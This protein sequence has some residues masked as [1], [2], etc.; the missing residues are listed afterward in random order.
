MKFVKWLMAVTVT[1]SMGVAVL[2]VS[3]MGLDQQIED[4]RDEM[5]SLSEEASNIGET[6]N[7]LEEEKNQLEAEG[8]K[9]EKE[10]DSILS[11][12]QNLNDDINIKYEEIEE[13]EKQLAAAEETEQEQYEMMKL[14]IKAMYE[15]GE[16]NYLE[17]LLSSSSVAELLN[18]VDYITSLAEYDNDMLEKYRE[19]ADAVAVAKAE[20]EAEL[21]ELQTM[22]ASVSEKQ[23]D[24]AELVKENQSSIDSYDAKIAKAEALAA[25]YEEKISARQDELAALEEQQAEEKRKA[26]EAKKNAEQPVVT[27]APAATNTPSVTDTPVVTDTPAATDEPTATDTPVTTDAPAAT[28]TPTATETPA[29]TAQPSTSTNGIPDIVHNS[30]DL[31]LI[32]AIVE[33]E[34]GNEPEQGKIAVANVV[35]NRVASSRYPNS[36]A[37]V[38]YQKYQFT[39]VSSGRFVI[40]LSRGANSSCVSAAQAAMSGTQA[41]GSNILHFRS[42]TNGISGTVIGNHVFY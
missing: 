32:A 28:E 37:E 39:P 2:T 26:E 40:V 29:P 18:K 36:V 8:A 30:S 11:E 7:G 14:H 33:C 31:A 38:L 16:V 23:Q 3:A 15:N 41:V 13:S 9:L 22:Q 17:I 34:A 27:N 19:A 12:L 10:L 21:E 25:E 4:K 35:L 6:I 42:A 20:L 24:V 5:D 1:V